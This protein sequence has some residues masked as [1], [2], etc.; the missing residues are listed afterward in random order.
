MKLLPHQSQDL[1]PVPKIV[2]QGLTT[3]PASLTLLL[4]TIFHDLPQ[5][6]RFRPGFMLKKLA[7][8][9]G[10]SQNPQGVEP[11]KH[12]LAAKGIQLQKLTCLPI[13]SAEAQFFLAILLPQ[14]FK[15]FPYKAVFTA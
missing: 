15:L 5:E 9:V 6:H 10:L 4:D 3:E 13:G 1:L 2:M 11:K 7:L 12:G 14:P 8:L